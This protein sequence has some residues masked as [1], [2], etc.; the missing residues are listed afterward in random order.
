MDKYIYRGPVM[1]FDRCVLD[2]WEAET[3]ATSPG[4]AKSNLAYR[5]KK[6]NN[7]IPGTKIILPGKLEKVS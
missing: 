6:R 5:W 3:M 1:E 4:K 7:R 2:K